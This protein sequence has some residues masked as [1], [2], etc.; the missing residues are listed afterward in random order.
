[1]NTWPYY[2]PALRRE[3]NRLLKAGGTLSG[4][5]A[6]P[7]VGTGP[8]EGS[9][10][11][12]LEREIEKKFGVKHAVAVNSGTAALHAALCALGV[13]GR[14]VITSPFT[15]SATVGA[16]PLAGGIPRFSD[17]GRFNFC[18]TAET[19]RPLINK[20]TAAILPVHIFGDFQN[21]TE[22]KKLGIPIIEDACQ[23]VGA[24]REGIYSGTVGTA[25]AY[26]F[27]GA[28]NLPSGE[29]GCLVTN[30]DKIAEKA[31]LLVNHAE[32][33]GQDWVGYN[34][35]MAEPIALIARHGLKD[36]DERN[37]R[38][39]DLAR[40]L[41][42]SVAHGDEPKPWLGFRNHPNVITPY[43]LNGSHVFYCVP[44]LLKDIDRTRFIARMAK[45][46]ITVGAG[47]I[48]PPLHHYPAFRKYAATPL[49]IV[50]E[51]SKKTL[52]LLYD[53]TPDKPLSYARK[54]AQAIRECVR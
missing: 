47:Y 40:T 10:A 17:V 1:M 6:N 14:E 48:Q 41:E 18:I 39:I 8:Q 35:R 31:R 13:Q 20:Q 19:V 21:L 44:F 51:L 25:G 23:A 38:R 37:Q 30:S 45:R 42:Q 52:C 43:A 36:L 5:R 26:S 3:M 15:F 32:N 27:N 12:K 54:V 34:Y 28:K 2:S 11:W 53:M 29:G 33:F 49:P 46:G 4:Y 24:Q 9:H 16:I 7:K 50:D 22:M